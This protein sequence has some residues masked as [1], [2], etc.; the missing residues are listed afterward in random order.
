MKVHELLDSPERWTQ[1]WLAKDKEGRHVSV[2]ADNATCFCLVGAVGKCYSGLRYLNV[3][4]VLEKEIGMIARW[5]DARG[6]TFDQVKALVERLD[7]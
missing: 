7:I 3:I 4:E 5:N 6:R 2:H 1:G